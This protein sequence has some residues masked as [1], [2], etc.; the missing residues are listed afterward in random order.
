MKLLKNQKNELYD[1]IVVHNFDPTDF[2]FY[3]SREG[4]NITSITIWFN[5]EKDY[6]FTILGNHHEFYQID[7]TPGLTKSY[8]IVKPKGWAGVSDTFSIWMDGL[9]NEVEQI[10]K[11]NEVERQLKNFEGLAKI[12]TNKDENKFTSN[13]IK[14]IY[15]GIEQIKINL[16]KLNLNKNQIDLFDQK[17]DEVK[18]YSKSMNKFNW[19]SFFIGTIG[20]LVVQLGLPPETTTQIWSMCKSSFTQLFN[21]LSSNS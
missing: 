1:K 12:T 16:K 11:W 9:S 14:N 2:T 17:L 13:E 5:K 15:V 18:E 8:N 21:L 19:K 7:F 4:I 6:S 20:N 3:E 10:D